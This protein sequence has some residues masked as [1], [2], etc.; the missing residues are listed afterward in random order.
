MPGDR[1]RF[2]DIAEHVDLAVFVFRGHYQ[3]DPLFFAAYVE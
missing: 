1:R 3:G 2:S